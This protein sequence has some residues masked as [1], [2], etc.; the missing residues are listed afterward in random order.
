MLLICKGTYPSSVFK[1]EIRQINMFF[2]SLYAGGL[3]QVE[4]VSFLTNCFDSTGC[5]QSLSVMFHVKLLF[6]FNYNVLYFL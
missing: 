6:G 4:K 3:N 5:L 2:F 1:L